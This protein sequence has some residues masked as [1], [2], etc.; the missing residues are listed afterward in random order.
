[1]KKWICLLLTVILLTACGKAEETKAPQETNKKPDIEVKIKPAKEEKVQ[2][3]KKQTKK[4][5]KQQSEQNKSVET[6]N[7]PSQVRY[8]TERYNLARHCLVTPGKEL[9][10]DCKAIVNTPEYSKAWNN[11]TSEGY[12]CQSGQCNINTNQSAQE[13]T[14]QHEAQTT[15]QKHDI[16]IT[17]EVIP[18]RPSQEDHVLTTEHPTTEAVETTE[19]PHQSTHEMR[20]T[21]EVTTEVQSTEQE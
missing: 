20:K 21:K 6:S 17:T 8:D 15:E 10:A 18:A 12:L 4:K 16:P 14:E 7:V 2:E 11:L 3:N 1:M 19:V 5:T 13:T 9:E